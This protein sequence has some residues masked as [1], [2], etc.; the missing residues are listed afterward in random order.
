MKGDKPFIKRVATGKPRAPKRDERRTRKTRNAGEETPDLTPEQAEL[1]ERLRELRLSIAREQ[2]VPPYLIFN[3]ATLEDM[4]R[5]RPA[6]TDELLE[7]SGVGE[8]KARKYGKAFLRTLA[9]VQED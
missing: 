5:K 6:T 9:Q 8:V 2:Q 4:C 3:N 7:V 1:F